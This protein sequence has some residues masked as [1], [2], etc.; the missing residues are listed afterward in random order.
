MIKKINIIKGLIAMMVMALAFASCEDYDK[1][2]LTD[3]GASRAFSPIN[4]TA[5]VTKQTT[6]ILDWDPVANSDHYV[7]EISADDPNFTTIFKTQN[8]TDAELPVS[9]VLEGLTNYS[10]RVRA[11]SAVGAEDSKYSTIS[12]LTQGEQLFLPIQDGD[13]KATSAILRWAPNTNATN[14]MLTPGNISH[15][16]TA[17]EKASGVATITG[18]TGDVSY[19]ANLMNGTKLRGT[20]TFKT[21][22]DIGDGI[23]VLESDDLKAVIAAAPIGAK[24]Y[25]SPGEYTVGA[26]TLNKPISLFGLYNYNKPKVHMNIFLESGASDLKL[27]DLDL[28]GDKGAVDLVKLNGAQVAGLNYGDIILS[29][30]DIHDYGKSLINGGVTVNSNKV[31]LVKVDGCVVTN[32]VTAGSADFIDFRVIYIANI[33]LSNSTFN[34]CATRDFIRVDNTGTGNMS[35]TGLSTSVL[36]DKCTITNSTSAGRILYVRFNSNSSKVTNSLFTD[37]NAMYTNQSTTNAPTFSNNNYFTC[38]A[39][40]KPATPVSGVKYDE[41]TTLTKLD[42]LFVDASKG[43][44]K[45]QN[46]AVKDNQQGD[47]RWLK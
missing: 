10:F 16:I 1:P 29:G 25:L 8:V 26:V 27:Q 11:V 38:P 15:V 18:L 30:C 21:A 35:G 14:L 2:L 20:M 19:T 4:L 13:I 23:L 45:V 5:K 28:N 32:M 47:P 34:S 22:V 17:E 24:L 3:I 44:F 37:L 6:V 46:D 40:T 41:S 43:N 39:L 9:I 33:S 7:V 31:N 36:I 42:P 12:I